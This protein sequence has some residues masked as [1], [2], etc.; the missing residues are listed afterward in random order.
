MDSH[1]LD[2]TFL[3]ETERKWIANVLNRDE[4]LQ[5][6]EDERIA[7]LKNKAARTN[8]STIKK[9]IKLRS[10][11]WFYDLV[12]PNKKSIKSGRET[13]RA[14]IRV[15]SKDG[16]HRRPPLPPPDVLPQPDIIIEEQDITQPTANTTEA[17]TTNSYTEPAENDEPEAE[18][19]LPYEPNNDSYND[20]TSAYRISGY[21]DEEEENYSSDQ[22][23][24][25]VDE[26][27]G[28]MDFLQSMEDVR[29][30]KPD[31]KKRSQTNLRKGNAQSLPALTRSALS[32]GGSTWSVYSAAAH[33]QTGIEITGTIELG[34]T[35]SYKTGILNIHVGGCQNL[36]SVDDKKLS[37]PY[38]KTYLLPDKH[39][40]RKTKTKKRTLNP[41]YNEVLK[42]TVSETELST[43]TLNVAVWHDKIGVNSFLGEVNLDCDH[44]DLAVPVK[45]KDYELASKD[46]DAMIGRSSYTGDV[47]VALRYVPSTEDSLHGTGDCRLEV[48]LKNV[49]N[50]ALK[51]GPTS[52]IYV[53]GYFL[54]DKSQETKQKTPLA[55]GGSQVGFDH[56]FVFTGVRKNEL[57]NRSVELTVYQREKFGH[58][59]IGG[60]RLGTGT[61][62]SFEKPVQWMDSRN[63]E[64]DLWQ[65]MIQAPE[66]WINGTVYLRKFVPWK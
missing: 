62:I 32:L 64:V 17:Y 43:R 33:D 36:A 8:N 38:V 56:Q 49:N 61:G 47:E 18:E 55:N 44:F 4:A 15:K 22:N 35:Y 13:V 39:S 52:Q 42:Y 51:G 6:K 12:Q 40:K 10:G 45:M 24:D 11:E 20:R 23:K 27:A 63:E 30:P 29:E 7:R 48:V 19:Q 26:L 21:I 14:S 59:L 65:R 60:V 16:Q 53:K 66:S 5:K 25:K 34:F 2:L 54:P 46:V 31:K 57:Y 1:A 9:K 37:N 3:T 58:K 41:V 50:V 28:A